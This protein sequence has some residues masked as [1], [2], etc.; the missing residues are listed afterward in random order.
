MAASM[1]PPKIF[2]IRHRVTI[3]AIISVRRETTRFLFC[4][5]LYIRAKTEQVNVFDFFNKEFLQHYRLSINKEGKSK[6][7]QT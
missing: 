1:P 7:F 6:N 2:W 5:F 3:Q 4:L